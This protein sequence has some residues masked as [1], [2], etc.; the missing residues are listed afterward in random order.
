MRLGL[1]IYMTLSQWYRGNKLNTK[2]RP[3]FQCKESFSLNKRAN[4]FFNVPP[5]ATNMGCTQSMNHIFLNIDCYG[6]ITTLAHNI[7]HDY[8]QV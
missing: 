2:I 8:S 7:N 5:M 3:T 4:E 1:G 6:H